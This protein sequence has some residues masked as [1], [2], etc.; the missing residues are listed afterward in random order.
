[1]PVYMRLKG[2]GTTVVFGLY[3]SRS[4]EEVGSVTVIVTDGAIVG[5]CDCQQGYLPY[6]W[7]EWSNYGDIDAKYITH[8]QP[9][10]EPPQE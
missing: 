6:P 10:P 8:W 7:V 3:D 5:V 2:N 4:D 1:M 9:L